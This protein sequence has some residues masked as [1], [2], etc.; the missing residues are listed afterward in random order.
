MLESPNKKNK[1]V[2]LDVQL[3]AGFGLGPTSQQQL[4]IFEGKDMCMNEPYYISDL[5]PANKRRP[6]KREK[7][8][9]FTRD[10]KKVC[11]PLSRVFW[12]RLAGRE[13]ESFT[14]EGSR[15]SLCPD[16]RLLGSWRRAN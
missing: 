13:S 2:I 9:L 3:M 6:S 16:W 1:S 12:P 5:Y 10:P 4:Q 11:R 8:R 14:V 15:L 7:Q